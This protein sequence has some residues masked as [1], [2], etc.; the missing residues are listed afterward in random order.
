M[1]MSGLAANRRPQIVAPRPPGIIYSGFYKGGWGARSDSK[2]ADW[3]Y[4]H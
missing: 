1:T 4:D 3:N 2:A